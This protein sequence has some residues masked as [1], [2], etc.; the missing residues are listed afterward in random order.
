MAICKRLLADLQQ[1][2]LLRRHLPD[3]NG[4]GPVGTPAVEPA[5]GIHLQQVAFLEHAL[6]GDAV[7]DLLVDAQST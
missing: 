2:G 7:D 1:P 3:R 5:G 4:D 6:A